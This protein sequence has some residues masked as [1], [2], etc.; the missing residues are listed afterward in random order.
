MIYIPNT[1]EVAQTLTVPVANP[2][3]V[4]AVFVLFS[5]VDRREVLRAEV[6]PEGGKRLTASFAVTLPDG[7]S[8]GEYEYALLVGGVTVESGVAVVGDWDGAEKQYRENVEY[9][10]YAG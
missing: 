2:L 6:T 7:L 9:K 1:P 3:Q 5:T 4:A 8:N 10:Q